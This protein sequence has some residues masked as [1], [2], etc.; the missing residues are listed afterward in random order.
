MTL[1]SVYKIIFVSI[2]ENTL[3]SNKKNYIEH[4]TLQFT[5]H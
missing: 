2:S 1:N 4:K 5:I 3:C